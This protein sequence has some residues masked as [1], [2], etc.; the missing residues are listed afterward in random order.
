[1][2]KGRR[3]LRPALDALEKEIEYIFDNEESFMNRFAEE[4]WQDLLEVTFSN[5]YLKFVYILDCGQHVVDEVE[6]EAYYLCWRSLS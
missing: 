4:H 1:V 2:P 5:S 6:I 3:F